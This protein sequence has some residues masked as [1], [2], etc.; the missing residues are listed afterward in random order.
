[1]RPDPRRDRRGGRRAEFC[2]LYGTRLYAPGLAIT[3]RVVK[4]SGR[5]ATSSP[6]RNLAAVC[7]LSGAPVP[8]GSGRARGGAILEFGAGSGVLAVELLLELERL[9]SLPSEYFILE[10]SAELRARQQG[11]LSQRAA[12]LLD[13]IRWLESLPAG[14]CAASCWQRSLDAMLCSCS[15]VAGAINE[16]C[17]A[18]EERDLSGAMSRGCATAQAVAALQAALPESLPDGYCSEINRRCRAG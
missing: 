17:V 14:V 5:R 7:A 16:R 3:A 6:R 12:H 18:C 1:V 13:R 9:D 2:P 15:C 10:L 4:N 8:A 11:L